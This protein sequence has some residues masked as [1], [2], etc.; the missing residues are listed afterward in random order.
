[1]L[2]LEE[3][4]DYKLT[5]SYYN[6][7]N[8]LVNYRERAGM[9]L[10]EKELEI[11]SIKEILNKP[12]V[13][14]AY[15]R[16][17]R[18]SLQSTSTLFMDTYRAFE[19]KDAEYRL[20]TVILHKER[21][22][23]EKTKDEKDQYQY[24]IVD[25]QQRLTTL[26]ILLYILGDKEQCILEQEYSELSTNTIIKNYRALSQRV[27][28]LNSEEEKDYKNY[29]L[30]NCKMVQIVTDNEQEAFQFFDSQNTRG[31]E[32]DPHDILKSYH[33]REM[34]YESEELKLSVIQQWEN[35]DAAIFQS[36]F[37]YYLYPLT[38]W[39]RMRNGLNYST[40]KIDA[41]KGIK[42]NNEYNYSRYHIASQ[43]YVEK[44]NK[45]GHSELLSTVKLNQFQL[46]QPLIAGKRFFYYTIHYKNLLLEIRDKMERFHRSYEGSLSKRGVGDYYIKI[47]YEGVVLFF[48]DRFG[49]D[50]LTDAIFMHLY[51]WSYSLRIT[52]YA[53]Y[54][55]GINKYA[56]GEHYRINKGVDMFTIISE[57]HDPK[58]LTLVSLQQ[59][60]LN[61]TNYQEIY[62]LLCEWNGW[63]KDEE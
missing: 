10:L 20:G 23:K 42:G 37:S 41:F 63:E 11:L 4:I 56:K 16:P 9:A 43:L 46:T 6:G 31:R 18:W 53:V 2:E 29:L 12:L 52:M 40:K 24:N 59:P 39:Y 47:M 55:E 45:S 17:Y 49:I 57:L 3:S 58:D 62:N 21:L 15:Q 5:W 30:N 32:L 22:N 35:I 36:L 50:S 13:L 54:Q 19:N 8:F 33:L 27:K 7:N 26:T 34:D 61:S 51:T 60:K 48:A 25:G 14:P 28:E 38:Q 44:F 1:M